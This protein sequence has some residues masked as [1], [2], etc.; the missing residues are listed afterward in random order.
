M[1]LSRASSYAVHALAYLAESRSGKLTSAEEIA[2]AKG[3]PVMFLRKC[4]HS[5]QQTGILRSQKGPT[6]GYRLARPPAAVTLLE[7]VEAVDGP[8]C[9]DAPFAGDS[10]ATFDSKL[11]RICDKIADGTRAELQKVTLAD[12]TGPPKKGK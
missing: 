8:I 2:T 7:I 3:L 11:Q 4:L 10:K 1:K 12:L 5:L 9:G 6:G